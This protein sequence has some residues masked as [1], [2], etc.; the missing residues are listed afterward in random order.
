MSIAGPIG[1]TGPIELIGITG[2]TGPTE[3]TEP[4]DNLSV[5]ATLEIETQLFNGR[6]HLIFLFTSIVSNEM[7]EMSFYMAFGENISIL[8]ELTVNKKVYKGKCVSKST[9]LKKA[10]DF[11]ASVAF[12]VDWGEESSPESTIIQARNGLLEDISGQVRVPVPEIHYPRI[13]QFL[14]DCLEDRRKIILDINIGKILNF[15]TQEEIQ[16]AI[17]HN[18]IKQ[19]IEL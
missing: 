4:I 17:Q 3:I 16:E 9:R 7:V 13:N 10:T 11:N 12:T 8:D 15:A 6:K 1:S 18:I 2:P 5:D 19:V 14:R